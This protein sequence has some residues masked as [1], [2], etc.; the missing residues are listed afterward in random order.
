MDQHHP[1]EGIAITQL[2]EWLRESGWIQHQD[3]GDRLWYAPIPN[4]AG[5]IDTIAF[6]PELLWLWEGRTCRSLSDQR[7]GIVEAEIR[8]FGAIE[9][10][11]AG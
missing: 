9:V 7:P 8:H 5:V 10:C 6:V 4:R 3:Q 11:H 2:H 1:T